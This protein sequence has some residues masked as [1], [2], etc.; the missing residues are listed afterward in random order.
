MPLG[1]R[2]APNRDP[3]PQKTKS[4][5]KQYNSIGIKPNEMGILKKL[6]RVKHEP[7]QQNSVEKEPNGPGLPRKTTE[8]KN[9]P[10]KIKTF[11]FGSPLMEPFT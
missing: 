1:E 3:P 10:P 9:L 5:P 7:K 11:V 4:K 2:R 8:S 6:V